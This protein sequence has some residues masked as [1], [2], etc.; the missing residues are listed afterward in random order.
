MKPVKNSVFA[1][2]LLCVF[3]LKTFAGD[4][5]TP[6]AAAPPPPP[7]TNVVVTCSENGIEPSLDPDYERSGDT[8][9]SSDYLFFEALSALLSVY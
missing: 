2:L 4:I 6:G 5:Q 3:A 1:A 9:E 8:V 7:P